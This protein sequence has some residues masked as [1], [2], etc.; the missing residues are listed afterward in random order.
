MY[1]KQTVSEE[2]LAEST[3][4]NTEFGV[5]EWLTLWPRVPRNFDDELYSKGMYKASSHTL[6]LILKIHVCNFASSCLFESPFTHT[7]SPC[8]SIMH[9]FLKGLSWFISSSKAQCNAENDAKIKMWQPRLHWKNI[10]SSLISLL[11]YAAHSALIF[12]NFV[13]WI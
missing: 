12:W 5:K 11:D 1:L 3:L 7:I 13:L 4:T 10:S 8:A 6:I 2:Y 9:C